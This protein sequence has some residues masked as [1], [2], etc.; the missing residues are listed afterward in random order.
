MEAP[1]VGIAV[2]LGFVAL[3]LQMFVLGKPPPARRGGTRKFLSV[4]GTLKGNRVRGIDLTG[5]VRALV[6]QTQQ[7]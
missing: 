6:S 5:R 7:S 3:E 2:A 4:N 1:G